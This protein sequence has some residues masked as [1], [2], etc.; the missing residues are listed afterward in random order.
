VSVGYDLAW[1]V[2]VHE[3]NR[4]MLS[5]SLGLVSQSY[6]RIDVEQFVED[7]IAGVPNPK[8]IDEVP[9]LQSYGA[10]HF[11][12]AISRPLGLTAQVRGLYGETPWRD[13][14]EGWAYE[15]GMVLDFDAGPSLDLPLGL[16]IGYEQQSTPL[17]SNESEGARRASVLRIAYNAKP[18]F[19]VAVDVNR[20]WNS[21]K[22]RE[23]E[24]SSSG[25]SLALRYYF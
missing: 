2:R 20:I 25:A 4:T 11:S 19:I 5:G 9:A 16:A 7:V 8:I 23:R 14:P 15:Y 1:L 17:L 22:D 13:E 6:T 10:A 21:T 12:W 18:D 24:L 3:S